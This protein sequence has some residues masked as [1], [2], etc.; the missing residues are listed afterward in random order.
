MSDDPYDFEF[1][2][3]ADFAT[4]GRHPQENERWIVYKTER[5][6]SAR[7]HLTETQIDHELV[8]A[9]GLRVRG[10]ERDAGILNRNGKPLTLAWFPGRP[11]T[12]EEARADGVGCGVCLHE[13]KK[14][15]DEWWAQQTIRQLRAYSTLLSPKAQVYLSSS[16][17]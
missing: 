8:F 2:V 1:K 5:G 9:C 4:F 13:A 17:S 15:A 16:L 12:A 3:S 11:V 10:E 14:R 7:A 6:P